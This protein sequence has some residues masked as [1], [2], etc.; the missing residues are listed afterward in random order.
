MVL[1]VTLLNPKAFIF[2]LTVIPLTHPQ[3]W[4]YFA[5]FAL[6]VVGC[7]GAWVLLGGAVGAAS[8][9][10]RQGMIQKVAAVALGG[11]AGV[12]LASAFA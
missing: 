12:I 1:V 4:L 10:K 6:C 8:R 5:A 2:A 7:G 11:F 3:L 9:G